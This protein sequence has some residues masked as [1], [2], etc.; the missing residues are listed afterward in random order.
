MSHFFSQ[1]DFQNFNNRFR[2][3]FFNSIVGFKSL[4]LAGSIS[5]TGH[6]N[7]AIF[8]SIFHIGS[9]PA[10]LGMIFRPNEEVPRHTLANILETGFYTFN[11]VDESFYKQAHHTSA[12][13]D[14]DQSEFEACGLEPY[15][16]DFFPAPFVKQS[17][18]KMGL[19]F[20]EKQELKFNNTILLVGKVEVAI[21]PQSIISDDGFVDISKAN[22]LAGMGIDGYAKVENVTRLSYSKVGKQP[23]EI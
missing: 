9:N 23:L 13:Y 6:H 16:L 12:K 3:N 20:V 11:H 17:Q 1:T 15:F 5:K 19:S 2:T 21:L 4:N 22:S 14:M 10:Y 18:V 8:S 7:L